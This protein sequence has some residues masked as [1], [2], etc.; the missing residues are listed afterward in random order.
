M[1]GVQTCALPIYLQHSEDSESHNLQTDSAI[2]SP[3]S[4]ELSSLPATPGA[5][6][7]LCEPTFSPTEEEQV[8]RLESSEEFTG[9][10]LEVEDG[11]LDGELRETIWGERR[12]SGVGS[13]LTREPL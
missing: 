11:E 1:T 9:A 4:E 3:T 5:P 13:S 8:D 7:T 10:D 6:S 12:D 2:V